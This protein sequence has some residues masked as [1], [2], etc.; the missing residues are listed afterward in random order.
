M[1][2][3]FVLIFIGAF[4]CLVFGFTVDPGPDD[5]LTLLFTSDIHGVYN[6]Y[7]INENGQRR[8]IGGM[9]ALSHY[10]NKIRSEE[11]DAVLIDCGDVMTGSLATKLKYKG[12]RGAV[13]SSGSRLARFPKNAAY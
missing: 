11:P 3:H 7:P 8:L 1:R 6:P 13:K 10:V 4:L 12:V 9:E 5:T 2:N